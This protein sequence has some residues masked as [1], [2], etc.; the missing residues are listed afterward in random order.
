MTETSNGHSSQEE[1]VDFSGKGLKLDNEDAG[2]Y[3][4]LKNEQISSDF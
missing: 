4:L 3:F 2:L 1:T